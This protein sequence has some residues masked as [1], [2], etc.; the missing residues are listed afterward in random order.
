MWKLCNGWGEWEK[1]ESC[2]RVSARFGTDFSHEGTLPK[3][4]TI[5]QLLKF[6]TSA[7]RLLLL[8]VL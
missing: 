8:L 4:V 1:W 2:G 7:G 5:G 6:S 3:V